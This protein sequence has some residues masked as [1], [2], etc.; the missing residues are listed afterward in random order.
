MKE[1][2][3]RRRKTGDASEETKEAELAN[4]EAGVEKAAEA[5][6]PAMK[7]LIGTNNTVKPK[8]IATNQASQ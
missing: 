8:A 5:G 2:Q 7:R 1:S 6:K 3:D 4:A